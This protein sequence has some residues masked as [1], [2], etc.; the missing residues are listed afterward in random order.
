MHFFSDLYTKLRASGVLPIRD[1]KDISLISLNGICQLTAQYGGCKIGSLSRVIGGTPR[2]W[3]GAVCRAS[4]LR[5]L[6]L[7]VAVVFFCFVLLVVVVVI[8]IL[9]F[10]FI[11]V[12][13]FIIFFFFVFFC[14]V[15]W[16]TQNAQRWQ[17]SHVAPTM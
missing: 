2:T 12:F 11:I 6:P 9:F 16:C 8:I 13:F 10:F 17:Q 15:L 1:V 5:R 3:C 4:I 7:L 14:M